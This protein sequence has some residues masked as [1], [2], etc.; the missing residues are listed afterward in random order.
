MITHTQWL[1]LETGERIPDGNSVEVHLTSVVGIMPVHVSRVYVLSA[2]PQETSVKQAEFRLYTT[3]GQFDCFVK[4]K[5]IS[6][7]GTRQLKETKQFYETIR[8][9][10]ETR[11]TPRRS[12]PTL[13]TQ[14]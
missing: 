8:T 10:W 12:P 2:G 5:D 13:P 14:P 6:D 7:G 4:T 11:L 3:G 9:M 1:I